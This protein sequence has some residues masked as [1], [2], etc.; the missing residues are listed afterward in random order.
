MTKAEELRDAAERLGWMGHV[1]PEALDALIAYSEQVGRVAALEEIGCL[2]LQ[3]QEP[4][5]DY[6]IQC[7]DYLPE[8]FARK[9]CK[10]CRMLAEARAAL[11]AM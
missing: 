3:L 2:L 11:E 9:A 5:T 7:D 10:C 6:Y 4:D 1:S 8:V